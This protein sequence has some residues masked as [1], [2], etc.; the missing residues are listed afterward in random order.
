MKK[1]RF[2]LVT[3]AIFGATTAIA[4]AQSSLKNPLSAEFNDIP[5]FIAGALKVMVMVALPVITFF[6]VYAGFKFIAAQG[7][8]EKLNEA[9]KNFMYVIIGALLILGAWIIA[10]LISGTV[11]QLTG[12]Q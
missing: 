3:V 7:S 9:K 5:K 2:A 8:P 11:S 4:F 12:V 1:I 6:V 10:N